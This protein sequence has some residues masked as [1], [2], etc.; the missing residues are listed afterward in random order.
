[1]GTV[2]GNYRWVFMNLV[3]FFVAFQARIVLTENAGGTDASFPVLFDKVE[4]GMMRSEWAAAG[5]ANED[6]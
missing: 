1:M 3:I 6:W 5:F 2:T 4:I